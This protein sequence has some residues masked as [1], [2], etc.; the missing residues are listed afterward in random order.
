M[1]AWIEINENNQ[2]KNIINRITW[3]NK[4]ILIQGKPI[5]S[6]TWF[7]IGIQ[8][9]CISDIYELRTKEFCK[10]DFLRDLQNL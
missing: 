10:F 1:K 5:F 9:T 4:N 2:N 8:H 7:E 3:I 6:K